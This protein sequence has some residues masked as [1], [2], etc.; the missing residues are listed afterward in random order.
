MNERLQDET[1]DARIE[2]AM[3]RDEVERGR[4]RE[5]E[6]EQEREELEKTGAM[7]LEARVALEREVGNVKKRLSLVL[8]CVVL[9]CTVV[10]ISTRGNLLCCSVLQ[11]VAVCCSV[12]QCAAVCCT[13]PRCFVVTH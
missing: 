2:V 13:V 3:L 11:C 7:H 1:T 9:C 8:C 12:L 6:R 4:E 10:V 5:R